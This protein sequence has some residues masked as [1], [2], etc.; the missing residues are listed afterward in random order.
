MTLCAGYV[1]K[2]SVEHWQNLFHMKENIKV[3][4][5]IMSLVYISWTFRMILELCCIIAFLAFCW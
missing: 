5:K 4:L 3:D 1:L 2:W